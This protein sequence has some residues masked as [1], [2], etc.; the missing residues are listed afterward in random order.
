MFNYDW[1]ENEQIVKA[2]VQAGEGGNA[3]KIMAHALAAQQVGL[4]MTNVMLWPD[5]PAND[6]PAIINNNSEA[7]LT[8]LDGL[9][10]DDFEKEIAYH[11]TKGNPYQNKLVD[12]LAHI[13]NHGTHHRA[14]AGKELKLHGNIQLPMTDYIFYIRQL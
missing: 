10:P 6:L 3:L 5:W 1:F 9:S 11:N 7:W 13:I 14:Q 8:Y 4:P 12:I 2:I